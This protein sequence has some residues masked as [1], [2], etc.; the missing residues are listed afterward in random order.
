MNALELTDF[1]MSK[2]DTFFSGMKYIKKDITEDG[3][4]FWCNILTP[5]K[6]CVGDNIEFNF[7]FNKSTSEIEFSDIGAT[8][9]NVHPSKYKMLILKDALKN[10]SCYFE[11]ENI[12]MKT[13]VKD[14]ETSI[15]EY[16][17]A[18][19][20]ANFWLYNAD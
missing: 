1:Y 5:F 14:F 4:I 12:C 18:L 17:Q 15:T 9:N 3:N 13:R 10:R 6:D 19:I 7:E 2:F 16:I 11:D 8:L 20:E